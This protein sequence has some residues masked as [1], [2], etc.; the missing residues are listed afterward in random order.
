[1]PYVLWGI[2]GA[3]LALGLF[4]GGFVAGWKVNNLCRK[5]SV[6][7][8]AE[9]LTEEEKRKLREEQLAFQQLLNYNADMA[10]GLSENN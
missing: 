9:A 6:A 7:A 1:M 4:A 3:V 5:K 10:Y 2:L 8:A